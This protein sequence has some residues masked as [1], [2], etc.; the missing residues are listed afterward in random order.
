MA[1]DIAAHCLD[2]EDTARQPPLRRSPRLATGAQVPPGHDD[3]DR[4]SASSHAATR[5]DGDGSDEDSESSNSSGSDEASAELPQVLRPRPRPAVGS[6]LD[7]DPSPPASPDRLAASDPDPPPLDDPDA[8]YLRHLTRFGPPYAY[9][10]DNSLPRPALATPG[11][12]QDLT[13]DLADP[14]ELLSLWQDDWASRFKPLYTSTEAWKRVWRKGKGLQAQGSFFGTTYFLSS[15][16]TAIASASHVRTP[17]LLSC[18]VCMTR[19]WRDIAAVTRP[20]P[21]SRSATTGPACGLT[22]SGMSCPA[23]LVSETG[24]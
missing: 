8:P 12:L 7:P 21:G 20:R 17:G 6:G 3:E 18:S 13:R 19:R 10:L 11:W 16:L 5:G 24:R 2:W 1:A 9:P 4:H 14:R 22:S 23:S 15:G